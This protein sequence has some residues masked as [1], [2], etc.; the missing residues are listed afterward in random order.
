VRLCVLAGAPA[1]IAF[2]V[3]A[4][5]L[6][7][8]A[9]QARPGGIYTC[10]VNGKKVTTDRPIAECLAIG[11]RELNP[12]GSLKGILPPTM[13]E[14]EKAAVERKRV[15]DEA[16]RIRQRDAERRDKNLM[17][18]FPNEPAHQK[19]RDKALDDARNAARSSEQR[20]AILKAERKPLL[21]EAE[22]YPPPMPL[23]PKLKQQ[24]DANEA[25]QKAQ[26]ELILNANAEVGRIN[27]LYDVE[28]AK[29]KRL[30]A[31][32]PLGSIGG[33]S[34][35]TVST[36]PAATPLAAAAS[37]PAASVPSRR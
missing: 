23:P 9:Q 33:G 18:R 27:S 29:L 19:A 3:A 21:A 36:S 5:A 8:A 35:A 20:L 12:D 32:A 25:S 34:M 24:L 11:Q 15:A 22:F 16:E 7:A 6:P 10:V 31:G 4:S 2:S 37:P 30:W 17:S 28:F 1:W 13:T 14:E 26:E